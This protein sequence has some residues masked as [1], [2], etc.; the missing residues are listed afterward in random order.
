MFQEINL[1]SEGAYNEL[2]HAGYPSIKL[3]KHLTLVDIKRNASILFKTLL[4]G[5]NKYCIILIYR[6]RKYYLIM[7][8]NK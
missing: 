1:I 4:F 2:K 6:W 8:K 5:K 7:R 3:L